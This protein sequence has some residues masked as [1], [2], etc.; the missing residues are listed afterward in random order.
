MIKEWGFMNSSMDSRVVHPLGNTNPH[1]IRTQKLP[2]KS[3]RPT[4]ALVHISL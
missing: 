1:R 2:D 4:T 3:S